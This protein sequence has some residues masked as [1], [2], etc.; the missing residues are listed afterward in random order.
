MYTCAVSSI[1]QSC[2]SQ[3][4]ADVW[5]IVSA[6]PVVDT[7]CVSIQGQLLTLGG[8]GLNTNPTAAVY[9][10]DQTDDSWKSVKYGLMKSRSQAFAAVLPNN[11][12]MVVGGL[13]EHSSEM[14]SVELATISYSNGCD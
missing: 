8:R 6:P 10:Y 14:D 13:N 3:S 9:I 7:S 1:I 12:L 11:Q 4:A 2:T 5:S